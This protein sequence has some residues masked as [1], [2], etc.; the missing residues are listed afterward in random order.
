MRSELNPD[1]FWVKNFS[2]AFDTIM[3]A[4]LGLLVRPNSTQPLTVKHTLAA[5]PADP[6]LCL[7][8]K[9]FVKSKTKPTGTRKQKT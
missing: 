4:A 2:D 6:A 9:A 8:P 3:E 1:A 7:Y 5:L